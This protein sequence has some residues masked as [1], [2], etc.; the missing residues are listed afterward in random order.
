MRNSHRHEN[1]KNSEATLGIYNILDKGE[2][3]GNKVL[4]FRSEK[5]RFMGR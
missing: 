2:K 5:G 3:K 1:S 4:D